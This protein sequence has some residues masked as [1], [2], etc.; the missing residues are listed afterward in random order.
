MMV[1]LALV[2]LSHV[3][4]HPA[5]ETLAEL[6]FNATTGR[7]EVALRL[8]LT[9]EHRVLDQRTGRQDGPPSRR[10]TDEDDLSDRAI[11][12]IG[13]RLR[14][15]TRGD[16]ERTGSSDPNRSDSPAS[17]SSGV[18]TAPV[19][20]WVGRQ[21]E[22]GHVWWFF[23]VAAAD[24][25]SVSHVRCDWFADEHLT[26]SLHAHHPGHSHRPASSTFVIIPQAR[27]SNASAGVPQVG[28]TKSSPRSVVVTP[29]D[30]IARLP[31]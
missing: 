31:W 6:Q 5:S 11:A 2:L 7:V 8:T 12:A 17:G 21:T 14:F 24:I 25:G 22:G 18:A 29:S 20:I 19:V 28:A 10:L 27:I 3:M 15:G 1:K 30:P 13:K 23:E 4:M 9:D 16:V 26:D